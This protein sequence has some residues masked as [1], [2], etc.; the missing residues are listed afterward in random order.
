MSGKWTQNAGGQSAFERNV[1]EQGRWYEYQEKVEALV[2]E[3]NT[4]AEAVEIVMADASWQPPVPVDM[5]EED[6]IAE[7]DNL[8]KSETGCALDRSVAWVAENL[9]N[10]RARAKDAPSG[11]AW[12]L[13]KW[14]NGNETNKSEFIKGLLS[15]LMPSTKE[16]DN[17]AR[18]SDDG[19]KEIELAERILARMAENA[20]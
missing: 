5:E 6:A 7:L 16:L 15:K 12:N 9:G 18:Y 13:L 11:T 14:A 19:S 8:V 20:A 10:K 1:S 3:G 4:L 17:Q 2:G